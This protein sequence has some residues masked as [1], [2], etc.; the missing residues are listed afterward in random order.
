M[1]PVHSLSSSS[2]KVRPLPSFLP[3]FVESLGRCL[4]EVQLLQLPAVLGDGYPSRVRDVLAVPEQQQPQGQAPS[5]LPSFVES[6]GRCLP[7]VQLL[8]LWVQP[9]NHFLVRHLLLRWEII[10]GQLRRFVT[11]GLSTL[12]DRSRSLQHMGTA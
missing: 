6:L 8:Q 11:L 9:G 1:R 10:V 3:S 7:E 5:F 12:V 4:P 2:H